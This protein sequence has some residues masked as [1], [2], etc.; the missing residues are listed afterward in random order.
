MGLHAPNAINGESP[1]AKAT[2]FRVFRI[3][4]QTG[5]APFLVF[6]FF[7]IKKD[8]PALGLPKKRCIKLI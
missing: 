8:S 6:I 3:S 1:Q 2:G 5:Y 4:R 7:D